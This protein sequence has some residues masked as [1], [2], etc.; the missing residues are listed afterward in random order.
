M[1]RHLP[2]KGGGRSSS[3][4][5]LLVL[6]PLA[7]ASPARAET[8]LTLE[9]AV[10]AAWARHLGLAAGAAGV[11]AARADAAAAAAGW[12]PTVSLTA[13]G[14]RT[15][16]PLMAFGLK[17]DQ[18]RIAAQD[19]DPARLNDPDGVTAVGAGV[20]VNQP[21]FAGGRILAGRRALAAQAEAEEKT[22]ERRAQELAGGVVEAY[23]G[24][25]VAELGVRYAD[26]FLAQA[27]ETER[28]VQARN[29]EGLSLDADVAR[30]I[31]DEGLHRIPPVSG[32]HPDV[33]AV[34]TAGG[35]SVAAGDTDLVTAAFV[36]VIRG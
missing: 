16:E 19:F 15:D 1:T 29:R 32:S 11:D 3:A 22:Q 35:E 14:V 23:F 4:L 34:V 9:D 2:R 21:L 10:R 27:R 26:D 7:F 13:R 25:Q 12:L 24:A 18:A 17:L 8:A 31:P 6:A 20:T 5:A 28:F 33:C 30:C 36:F